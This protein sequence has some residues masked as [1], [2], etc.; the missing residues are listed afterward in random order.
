MSA[1]LFE[2]ILIA[3]LLLAN[4]V[5][6]MSEMA[7][8]S[9]RKARLKTRAED[10]DQGAAVALSLAESPSRFLSTVQIGITLI[11]IFA[12][13]VGG[14]TLSDKVGAMI[15][16]IP[17]IGAYSQQIAFGLVVG[18][19][20]YGSLVFG[21]LVPKRLALQHPEFI[22]ALVSR[23]M[24]GLSKIA[25]PL[26]YVLSASTEL[27]FALMRIQPRTDSAVTEEE[28]AGM[29]RE[30]FEAGVLHEK[31]SEIVHNVLGLDRLTVRHIMTPRP[32]I[33]WI[34][35]NDT[36]EAVWHKIVVS[37]HSQFPVYEGNLDHIVGI[38]SVKS[39]YANIAAGLPVKIRE[40]TTPALIIPQM[41]SAID[42]LE[43]LKRQHRHVAFATDEYGSVTGL[44]TLNDITEAIVGEMPSP[45]DRRT[46]SFVKR[47]DGSVLVD[48]MIGIEELEEYFKEI[49]LSEEEERRYSTLAGF[50]CEQL[51]RIP[52]EGE[53]FE[54]EG[55][56][57]E[58][59]DMDRQRVDKVLIS[60][61]NSAP[62][63]EAQS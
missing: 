10:G 44:V 43:T 51:G 48:A 27:I 20:T 36:H 53:S 11:G 18:S 29:V 30:G 38:L 2:V 59:L 33:V 23:P 40:L 32:R 16:P 7:L 19:I 47:D 4:G 17:L 26:V 41:Q 14:A 3:V 61:L 13:A 21:E 63:A 52:G 57:F 24:L 25:S 35:V 49:D 31:E 55:Y 8:V 42:L 60:K 58:V 12:G 1:I 39:I 46:Q 56:R 62:P 50:V 6:A 45:G 28:V 37:H 5:F 22:S 34:D 9:S 54:F 15:A